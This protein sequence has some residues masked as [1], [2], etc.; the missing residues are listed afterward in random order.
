MHVIAKKFYK[1]SEKLFKTTRCYDENKITKRCYRLLDFVGQKTQIMSDYTEGYYLDGENTDYELAQK[2]Q[3]DFILNAV[4]CG[5]DKTL[6][7][8]GCGNGRLLKEAEKRGA[9]AVGITVCQEQ[10]DLLRKEGLEVY[11]CDVRELEKQFTSNT[12]DAIVC[13]GSVEYYVK[14]K[15]VFNKTENVIY[16]TIF[17][18]FYQVTKPN[19]LIATTTIHFREKPSQAHRYFSAD[20]KEFEYLSFDW[21]CAVLVQFYGGMYPTVNQLETCSKGFFEKI[22]E[23]DATRDYDLTSIEW[24]KR[25]MKGMRNPRKLFQILYGMYDLL[26]TDSYHCYISWLYFITGT[27]GWQFEGK[28]PPMLHLWKV[29]KRV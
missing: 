4:C 12:F 9:R 19:A 29:W 3:I 21:R 2:Y 7:E 17:E 20:L 15:D 27:W 22:Y 8:V 25:L 23:K 28:S 14:S 11:L 13:N 6:L 1:L 24:K 10:V 16:K 5:K 18:K 26:K